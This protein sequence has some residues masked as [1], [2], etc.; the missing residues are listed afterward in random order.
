MSAKYI[1]PHLRK[2]NEA[3]TVAVA[4]SQLSLAES[5]KVS[6]V[7]LSIPEILLLKCPI[8]CQPWILDNETVCEHHAFYRHERTT[9]I[10]N[11]FASSPEFLPWL[12]VK[13]MDK[14]GD[15]LI[16]QQ[17][18][19]SKTNIRNGDEVQGGRSSSHQSNIPTL[20]N[21][22]L[23]YAAD[24]D[25]GT[26]YVA[27]ASK[28]SEETKSFSFLDIGFAPGGMVSL[29][30]DAHPSIKGIGINL[31]PAKG[32]NVFP[33]ELICDRFQV[34]T[35]DV[36]ELARNP[37]L[38]FLS[39]F[40]DLGVSLFDLVIVGITTSGSSQEKVDGVDELELKNLL[41]F[42]QLLLAF[43][44]LKAGGQILIRMHLG[45]RLVDMHMLAFLLENFTGEAKST[46]PLTEFAMRKTCWLSISGFVPSPDA[47]DRLSLLVQPDQA[48]PYASVINGS[49]KL[50]SAILIHENHQEMLKKYGSKMV[51]ILEPMWYLQRRVIEAVMNG[52]KDKVCGY[53]RKGERPCSGCQRK[54]PPP[55]LNAVVAV[56][57]RLDSSSRNLLM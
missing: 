25:N 15:K 8:R 20:F 27:N 4:M 24:I 18:Q 56:K 35:N 32:G 50:N 33:E 21:R 9:A 53:C 14:D 48:S 23:R 5:K 10:S 46:K 1:P 55:I 44:Y 42:S 3:S 22:F 2:S 47:V 57:T 51:A 39:L 6:V 26:G 37:D 17:F 38:D 31:D 41:H 19:R 12:Q 52:M 29:L 43:K 16:S 54:V 34:L 11:F 40:P 49:E 30:L 36:I 45:L 13:R 7:N 28:I